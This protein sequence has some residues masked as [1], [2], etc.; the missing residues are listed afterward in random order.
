MRRPPCAFAAACA[1]ALAVRAAGAGAPPRASSLGWVRLPGAEACIGTRELATAV[2]QRLGRAVFVSP[3]QAEVFVEGR[4]EA[5]RAGAAP[6]EPSPSRFRAHITLSDARG[7][8]LGTRDL[9][10]P[11]EGCR[12]LDEQLALVIALLIDPDAVLS[13]APRGPAPPPPVVE[14]VLVPVPAPSPPAR[15]PWRES[16]AVGPQVAAGLLPRAGVALA[17]RGEIVPPSFVPIELGGAVWLDAHADAG[18]S[19]SKGATLSLAYGLLGICPL[20]WGPGATRVRGCADLE[21]GA[22][23]AVGYGFTMSNGTGQ[24][25]PVV[26]AQVAGRVT[27]RLVGPLDIGVGLGLLVPFERARFF[28]VDA[29]GGQQELFRTAPVAGVV[30]ASVGLAFP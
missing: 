18:A 16:L 20:A 9:E 27:R 11:G 4:V 1:L 12:T 8:V 21:V 28:Y 7:A 10:A 2:E 30:D 6:A 23:R 26:Q 3:A 14:R 22:I 5:P 25:Q 19:T 15:E 29:S 17:L 13:G 24:E